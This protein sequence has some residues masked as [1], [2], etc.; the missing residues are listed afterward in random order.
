MKQSHWALLLWIV[1]SVGCSGGDAASS[2]GQ[3][4]ND[5]T[6]GAGAAGFTTSDPSSGGDPSNGGGRGSV[7]NGGSTASGGS[8]AARPATGG[9]L[10]STAGSCSVEQP[11]DFANWP[12]SDVP[13]PFVQNSDKSITDTRTGLTWTASSY[14]DSYGIG[15]SAATHATCLCPWRLAQRIELESILDFRKVGPSLT[16]AAGFGPD[17]SDCWSATPNSLDKTQ[18]WS[19]GFYTGDIEPATGDDTMGV[20]CVKGSSTPPAVRY[21]LSASDTG[22][23][24]VLDNGTNLRWK[25]ASE[26]DTYR[27]S[28]G[29]TQ[30]EGQGYRLPS[31][32]ELRSLLNT[33]QTASPLVDKAMFPDTASDWYWSTTTYLDGDTLPNYWPVDFSGTKHFSWYDTDGYKSYHVRCVR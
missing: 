1:V 5:G 21:T 25:Q 18:Q 31:V 10:A 17:T 12:V 8:T 16:T 11:S 26:P 4:T 27:Q 20:R 33:S 13:G 28:D 24:E 22:V 19:V 2:S 30:C 32:A 9:T 29:V 3:H 15:Q 6:T 23:A 14:G 7:A